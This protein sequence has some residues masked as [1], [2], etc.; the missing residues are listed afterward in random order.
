MKE[1]ASVARCRDLTWLQLSTRRDSGYPRSPRS[2]SLLAPEVVSGDGTHPLGT[3]R[4]LVDWW[5][6]QQQR[7]QTAGHGLL[8]EI[9]VE[10]DCVHALVS[11]VFCRG[12]PSVRRPEL[13][14]CLAR[15]GRSNGCGV[16]EAIVLSQNLDKELLSNG[17]EE[18]IEMRLHVGS[19]V[20]GLLI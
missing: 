14:W 5:T 1:S 20:E 15:H 11:E 4:G 12:T 18:T 9:I 6:S 10:N 3:L 13:Q 2:S 17:N 7:R 16:L 8:G 19:L